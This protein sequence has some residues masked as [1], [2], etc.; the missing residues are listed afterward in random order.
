M[1]GCSRSGAAAYAGAGPSPS[2]PRHHR[3]AQHRGGRVV[4]VALELRRQLDRARSSVSGFESVCATRP[5]AT[6]IPPTTAAADDPR[7]R[8]CGMSLRQNT[9][10]P[11]AATPA[12]A[13]P[14]SMA[15]TT[16]CDESSGTWP[17]P[18][19]STSMVRPDSVV[20]TSI[21]SYRLSARPRLSNPGPRFALDAATTALAARPAGR[22]R[23]TGRSSALRQSELGDHRNGVD[24]HGLDD[25][26]P[27][28]AVSG[29]LRPLPGDGAH[30]G[31]TP[32]HPAVLDRLS[33][34]ATLAAD[35]GSTKTPSVRATR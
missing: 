19:P 33:R 3:A 18:S 9:F 1:S 7:P 26:M 25:G 6:A 24:R 34:P 32:R 21:S 12:A 2:R 29:S 23:V 28:S 20:S 8:E 4:R 11:A 27:F 13:R 31:G 16:R 17:A 15:R 5:L 30:H 35:A 10:S 22:I 14:R